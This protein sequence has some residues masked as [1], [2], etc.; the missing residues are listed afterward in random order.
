SGPNV[1][2]AREDWLVLVFVSLPESAPAGP[3]DTP[4]CT[5]IRIA[6]TELLSACWVSVVRLAVPRQTNQMKSL[7]TLIAA[8]ALAVP[9]SAVP[10]LLNAG[11]DSLTTLTSNAYAGMANP[12]AGRLTL[13]LSHGDHFH[14]IGAYSYSGPAA[15]P[16]VNPTSSNNRIPEPFS[17]E[18]PLPLSLG[19]GLY[20]G[21]LVNAPGASEYS[22]I[23]FGSIEELASFAPGSPEHTL[24]N[25][26]AGRWSSS[27]SGAVI[28]LELLS[29]TPGLNVGTAANMDIF[30]SATYYAIGSGDNID[31]RPVFW[32]EATAPLGRYSATMRLVDLRN[33]GALLPSG[34]FTF[35]FAAVPEPATMGL[36]GAGLAAVLAGARRRT[37]RTSTK[38]RRNRPQ[39]QSA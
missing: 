8:A 28:A 12:N 27:L 11:V 19:T 18:P 29:I 24:L 2:T 20:R 35:D 38:A 9:V 34:E 15:A 39:G 5:Q 1:L 13:L 26:S 7:L 21:K 6:G 22:D 16:V 31:F 3:P 4:A 25:S 17:A 36:M 10:V 32:T 23:D 33:S 30:S 14:A 37:W